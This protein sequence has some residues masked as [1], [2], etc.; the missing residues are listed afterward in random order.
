MTGIGDEARVLWERAREEAEERRER[1]GSVHV[2]AVLAESRGPV[3]RL[4]SAHQVDR[5]WVRL[6]TKDK[7]A[8]DEPGASLG[9]V[10]ATADRIAKS[11]HARQT[12]PIHLLVALLSARESA[13]FRLLESAGIEIATLHTSALAHISGSVKWRS[14]T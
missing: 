2:L 5:R 1:F 13:A 10:E 14:N 4:L 9:Q 11:A 3:G 12:A 6:R 8:L 7:R